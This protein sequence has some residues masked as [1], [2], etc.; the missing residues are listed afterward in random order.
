MRWCDDVCI[1]VCGA[2][3]LQEALDLLPDHGGTVHVPTGVYELDRPVVKSLQE[4]QH[5]H[6]VGEGRAS[7][8]VNRN[9]GGEPL[10]QITGVVGAWWPDLRITIRDIAFRGNYES[11]DGLIIE[12]PNDALVDA[13]FFLG[14]GGNALTLTPHGTNVAIRDC[15]MRDCKRGVRADNIH[16]LTLHGNQTRYRQEGQDREEHLYLSWDCREVRVVN[17]HFAYGRNAGIILDGTAQHVIANNTIEGFSVAIDARGKSAVY[18]RDHCRDIAIASN[19]LHAD[20]GVRMTGECRGFTITG[21]TFIN[22]LN[23]AIRVEDA[24]GGG[25]H[26]ITGNVIRK[27]VYGGDFFPLSGTSPSQG[28]INLGG[29]SNCIVSG[30]ILDGIFPNPAISADLEGA[31][32][33]ITGNC[34]T[35]DSRQGMDLQAPDCVV[36]NNVV[37]LQQ[38]GA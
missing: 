25:R 10:L 28:G 12:Y 33:I 19:Y 3:G 4:G 30:N 29:S 18:P 26:A 36:E 32:H 11:G 38:S 8:L 1:N 37:T 35:C 7:V 16:H 2:V 13:C 24:R 27:S 22:N 21:N 34:I 15:W 6:L 17:N 9:T 31:R 23:A 20:T 5:L 14:H